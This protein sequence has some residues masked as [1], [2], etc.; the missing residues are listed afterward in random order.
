VH[1][2]HFNHQR[3]LNVVSWDISVGF[4]LEIS[5]KNFQNMIDAV[6]NILEIDAKET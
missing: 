4:E 5:S 2:S 1:S 3:E 6:D